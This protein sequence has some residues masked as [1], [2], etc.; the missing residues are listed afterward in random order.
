MEKRSKIIHCRVT[1]SEHEAIAEAAREVG[2]SITKFV[3]RAALA[4]TPEPAD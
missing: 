2:L 3:I 1:P 4:K